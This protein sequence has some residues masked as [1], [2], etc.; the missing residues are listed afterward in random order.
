MKGP[1]KECMICRWWYFNH[2]FKFQNFVYN[3][4]H[5]LTML[6]LINS[7]TVTITIK[8][9]NYHCIFHDISKSEEIYLLENSW[10]HIKCISTE[11]I[12]KIDSININLTF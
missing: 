12:L 8:S 4:C 2:G 9:V 5:D 6:C 7:D 3:G 10:V 1:T 11:A